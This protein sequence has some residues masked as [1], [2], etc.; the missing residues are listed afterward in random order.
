MTPSKTIFFLIELITCLGAVY[1]SNFLFFYMKIT[2]GF[3][4]LGNLGLAALYGF[5]YIFA[6]WQGGKFAQRHG[7]RRSLVIGFLGIAASMTAGLVWHSPLGQVVTLSGWTISVCF[8]WP[9]LEAIVT[10]GDGVNMSD[11]VGFYNITWALGGALA[12]FFGGILLERLG[13]QSL[14]W[15]PLC[16]VAAQLALIPLAVHLT[17][18]EKNAVSKKPPPSPAAVPA[19]AG[20]RQFLYLAWLANPLAYVAINTTIP[21]IPSISVKLGLSTGAAGIFCSLWMF[22]RLGAFVFLWRWTWWHY[23]FGILALSFAVMVAGFAGIVLATSIPMLLAAQIG[24]GL[25]VGLI[26][27]SSLYYSMNASDERGAHGGLHE[28]MI[29]AGLF[30]GPACGA[31]SIFLLP[32]VAGAG[33]ASV[34]G[35]LVAGMTGLLAM[36]RRQTRI[37]RA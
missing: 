31:F 25:S 34:G 4:E 21:L 37:Q 9:A 32:A 24:F 12:Y 1:Y 33:V 36:R 3:G 22:A 14:F 23:R 8:I 29:G 27:Y 2:F 13:L 5:V 15:L 20:S 26:Y 35:L 28:A 16:L 7:C 17:K 10:E 11:M 6:A 18:T 19:A 30:L